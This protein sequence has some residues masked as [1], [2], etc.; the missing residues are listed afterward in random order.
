[1]EA[2]EVHLSKD[3][4]IHFASYSIS[5]GHTDKEAVSVKF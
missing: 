4:R 1:M 5:F 3:K 2:A